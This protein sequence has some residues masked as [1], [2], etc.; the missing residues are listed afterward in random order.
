MVRAPLFFFLNSPCTCIVNVC[1]FPNVSV[2]GLTYKYTESRFT[3]AQMKS[4]I[5]KAKIIGLKMK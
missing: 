2:E 4:H 1:V 3:E 5:S